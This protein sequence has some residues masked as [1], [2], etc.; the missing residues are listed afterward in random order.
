MS[1]R[2]SEISGAAA[3]GTTPPGHGEPPLV[4]PMAYFS[5]LDLFSIGIGPSSSHTVGPMRAAL[6]FADHLAASGQ[7]PDVT[8]VPC[9]LYGSLGSTGLGHGTP[10][11]ILAGLAGLRPETC[12]PEAVRGSWSSLTDDAIFTVA[13]RHTI[14]VSQRDIRFESTRLPGH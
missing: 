4:R 13:G 14:S 1:A 9:S 2:I 12:D 6:A 8:G 3:T 5:A 10:D 11:A 7:L